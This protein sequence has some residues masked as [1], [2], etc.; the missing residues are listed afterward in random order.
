MTVRAK[1]LTI[2]ALTLLAFVGVMYTASRSFLLGGFVTLENEAAQSDLAR[3]RDAINDDIASLDAFNVDHSASDAT[4]AEMTDDKPGFMDRF[5]GKGSNGTLALQHDNY[6]LLIDNSAKIV[7]YR[8]S[9][10]TSGRSTV[11]PESLIAKITASSPLLQHGTTPSKV[12]G[13][14]LLPE[15]ALLVAARPIVQTNTAGPPRGTS[16]VARKLD[17]AELKRLSNRVHLTLSLQR[18]NENTLLPDFR[19]ADSYLNNSGASYIQP[20]DNNWIAAYTRLNDIYG[21]PAVILR[22]EI[23]RDIYRQGRTSQLYFVGAML[24]AALAFGGLVEMMLDKSV[25][26]KLA[27]LN[28]AVTNIATTIDA[29]AAESKSGRDEIASRATR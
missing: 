23:P 13:I 11:L 14:L 9:D 2:I 17:D 10:F 24:L 27:A 7:E 21:A 5:F 25:V 28:V 6:L 26:S 20:L 12:H 16:L 3:A 29:S 18:S 1:T 19:A 15:G 8:A 22:A 4:Y